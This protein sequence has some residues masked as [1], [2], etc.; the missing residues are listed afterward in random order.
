MDGIHRRGWE[1]PKCAMFSTKA[2]LYAHE[3]V[4]E[5]VKEVENFV[6]GEI[7]EKN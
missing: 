3:F 4:R 1:Y 5:F 6:G 7:N 2:R